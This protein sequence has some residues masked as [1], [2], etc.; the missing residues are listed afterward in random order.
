MIYRIDRQ[1]ITEMDEEHCQELYSDLMNIIL[2]F[3]NNGVIHC[4]YNEFNIMVN[5]KNKPIIIDF[6]QM[7]STSHPN[8]KM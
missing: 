7:I 8:A 6:P 3:A 4:D 2:K 5:E 1:K